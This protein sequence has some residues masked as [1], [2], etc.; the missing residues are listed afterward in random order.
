MHSLS[1]QLLQEQ[2]LVL[3][4]VARWD[5]GGG[6]PVPAAEGGRDEAQV[7]RRAP[8]VTSAITPPGRVTAISIRRRFYRR[9]LKDLHHPGSGGR[10]QGT[11]Q[12]PPHPPAPRAAPL[13]RVPRPGQPPR[14]PPALGSPSPRRAP[15]ASATSTAAA[16]W[17]GMA[18]PAGV[19]LG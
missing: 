12:R 2:R 15:R 18:C 11:P 14:P 5:S 9:R 17:L 19:G 13:P 7:Q 8:Y 10:S 3:G 16:G 1:S 6:W 4:W